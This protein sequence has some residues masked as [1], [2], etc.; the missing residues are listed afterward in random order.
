MTDPVTDAPLRH[1]ALFYRTPAEYLAA[2][3]GFMR[4]ALGRGE[5]VL[6]AVP[7]ERI[8]ALA[9]ELGSQA[10]RAGF[11][12][13][14]QTGRNP[15]AILPAMR[16][17]IDRHR[18]ERVSYVGEFTWPGRSPAELIETARHDA[19]I[20]LAFATAPVS[21]LCPYDVASLPATALDDARCT[22]AELIERGSPQRNGAYLGPHGM[23]PRCEAPLGAAPRDAD[24]LFYRGDLR[25]LRT[26]VGDAAKR[27]GLPQWRASDL[28][29]A[30][31]EVAANTLRHAGGE[32]RLVIW[33]TMGEIVCEIRD[34]GRIPDP[35]AGRVKPPEHLSGGQGLW[36]VN[37]VCDLV[38]MRS[39]EA[40]TIVRLHMSLAGGDAQPS[41]GQWPVTAGMAAPGRRKP[42][43]GGRGHH[44]NGPASR[45]VQDECAKRGY[46]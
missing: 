33:Q 35:L 5:S 46:T 44:A 8:G 38:E 10:P 9:R 25:P 16:A 41:A 31:S 27:A 15:G 17:F 32:G 37:K 22:H 40:G 39:G 45:Q 12:D 1:T 30:T 7:G 20:N 21:V 2:V 34:R 11:V 29:L 42:G 43:P 3:P 6:A 36:V 14:A 19:L 24:G 28:V 26:L 23:P 18:G 13:M 4:S